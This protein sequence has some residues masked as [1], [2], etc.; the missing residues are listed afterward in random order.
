MSVPSRCLLVCLVILMPLF[1][2]CIG[3]RKKA[4]EKSVTTQVEENFKHRWV[5]KRSAELAG[6]GIAQDEARRQALI[7]FRNKYEF[8]GAAHQ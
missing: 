2:G 5:E 3:F 1:A 7:E 4:E 8:T 6:Q